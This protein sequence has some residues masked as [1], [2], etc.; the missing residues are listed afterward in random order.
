MVEQ[1]FLSEFEELDEDHVQTARKPR[2]PRKLVPKGVKKAAK[3]GPT[4]G[5]FGNIWGWPMI[6]L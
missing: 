6:D 4:K 5:F 1:V 2:R 3:A